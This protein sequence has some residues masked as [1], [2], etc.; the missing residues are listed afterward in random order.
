[1]TDPGWVF[2][3]AQARAVVSEK[4]SLLSHTAI[5]SRELGKPSIVGISHITERLKDNDLVQVDG[6]S[7]TL[8][9]LQTVP[10]QGEKQL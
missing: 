2:L 7:G 9:I 5:I 8:T 6:D 1:M 3:I 4:G 10:R